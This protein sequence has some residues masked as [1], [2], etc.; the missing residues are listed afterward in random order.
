MSMDLEKIMGLLTSNGGKNFQVNMRSIGPDSER[1]ARKIVF[2]ALVSALEDCIA[3][4]VSP[5]HI[6]FDGRCVTER[7]GEVR[8]AV[9]GALRVA[10]NRCRRR[11]RKG[12]RGPGRPRAM[13]EEAVIITVRIGASQREALRGLVRSGKYPTMSEAIRDA[14]R[15]LLG[16]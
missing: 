12:K 4:K 10:A 13:E 16:E 6:W 1:C 7:I 3:M 15:R 8:S 11:G 9:E 2:D 5:M 14:I